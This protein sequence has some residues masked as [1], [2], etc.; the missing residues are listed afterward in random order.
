M[1]NFMDKITGFFMGNEELENTDRT[2]P[3]VVSLR[4]EPSSAPLTLHRQTELKI[5]AAVPRSYKE[6]LF[7]AD[8]IKLRQAV[9]VNLEYIPYHDVQ[10]SI[11]DFLNGVCYVTGGSVERVSEQMLLYVP[12]HVEISKEL[13]SF[14]VPTYRKHKSS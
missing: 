11:I 2:E 3:L 13:Y 14:S 6:A 8:R 5:L 1:A 9:A 10:Q 4:S 12:A 7:C